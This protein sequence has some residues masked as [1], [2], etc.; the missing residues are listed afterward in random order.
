[1]SVLNDDAIYDEISTHFGSMAGYRQDVLGLSKQDVLL[2][3]E[4]LLQ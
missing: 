3:Q 2:F 1:M 4:T